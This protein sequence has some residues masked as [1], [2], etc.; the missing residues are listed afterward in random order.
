MDLEVVPGVI[1][2]GMPRGTHPAKVTC[3]LLWSRG[4]KKSF[5]KPLPSCL[6]CHLLPNF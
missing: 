4:F 6:I 1:T 5:S 3:F 2:L